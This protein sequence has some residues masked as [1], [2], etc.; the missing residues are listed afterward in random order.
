[1][2][3]DALL[4]SGKG[5][6]MVHRHIW[7]RETTKYEPWENTICEIQISK[8]ENAINIQKTLEIQNIKCT[9]LRTKLGRI[10]EDEVLTPKVILKEATRNFERS[11]SSSYHQ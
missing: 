3:G 11:S 10:G 7:T 1:M 4:V 9:V 2:G 8:Y 6:S 5:H